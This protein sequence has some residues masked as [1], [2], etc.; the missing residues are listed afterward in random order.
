[1]TNPLRRMRHLVVVLVALPSALSL[2]TPAT[3]E[4]GPGLEQQFVACLAEK[5]PNLIAQIRDAESQQGFEAGMKAGLELCPMDTETMSM[6]KLFR[7]LN[8]HQE[9]GMGDSKE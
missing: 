1:M 5:Q 6:A 4:D 2:A 7:A 9:V 8:A 3:A